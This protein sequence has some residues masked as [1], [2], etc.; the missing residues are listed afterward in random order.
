VSQVHARHILV[1]DEKDARQLLADLKQGYD[2][3]KLAQL[4]SICP[5]G[6][7]GDIVGPIKT[8]FGW[9]IIQVLETR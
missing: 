8:K 9:H 2:F 1:R 6:K 3:P 5:S 7:K 4:K